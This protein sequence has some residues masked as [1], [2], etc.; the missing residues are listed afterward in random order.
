MLRTTAEL[1]EIVEAVR[2]RST[3]SFAVCGEA[4]NV[5]SGDNRISIVT[6]CLANVLYHRMYCRPER[7]RPG[8][9]ADPRAARMFVDDLSRANC[10][11]GTWE[12]GWI[13]KEIEKDGTL[14][15]HK[16]QDDLTLWAQPEQFRPTNGGAGLGSVGRL[17]LAKELR[18]ML[19]GYYMVLGNADQGSED[20]GHPVAIVRFYWHLTA[21]ASALWITELTRRF[22]S[23]GVAFRAKVLSDPNAY[24]RADAAVLYVAHTDLASVMALLPDLHT[25]VSPQ[26][27]PS[28][29][30]FTKRLVRGLATAEDPG[31]GRSFGQHRCQLV[32]E[33]LVRAFEA[34][35]TAFADSLAAV[36]ARFAAEGLS[37]TRP[38]LSAGSSESYAWPLR[39]LREARGRT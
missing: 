4:F 28:T 33:G 17:R 7:N 38:W 27:R 23:A 39:R 24:I 34:G 25:A 32:A 6:S 14:V 16:Q 18:G 12:P 37:V 2:I 29:P 3:D 11:T 35:S 9:G 19:P 36:V 5:P 10:G 22:N 21:E 31:D 30:M 1:R 8:L 20:V 13:V 26:L 15:V